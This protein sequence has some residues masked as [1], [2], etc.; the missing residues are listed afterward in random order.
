M[1]RGAAAAVGE[2]VPDLA[3]RAGN[4]GIAVPVIVSRAD[5]GQALSVPNLAV[6]AGEA[7]EAIPVGVGGADAGVRGSVEDLSALAGRNQGTGTLEHDVSRCTD[8]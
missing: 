8:T 3:S 5:A 4:T 7:D 1:A 2:V 6:A